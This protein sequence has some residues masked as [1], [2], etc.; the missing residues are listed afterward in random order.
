MI[1]TALAFIFGFLFLYDL[2]RSD[3]P[4]LD[5]DA[6]DCGYLI[7]L[8]ALTL[9]FAWTPLKFWRLEKTL[10]KHAA[11][12][13]E[14]SE[15]T[16]SCTSVFDS[17]FDPYDMTRA[18]SAYF[19]TGEIIFHYGWCK[20]FMGYLEDP[21]Y[22]SDDELFSMHL[23]THEVMHIRGERNE[24]ETDCQA[25]QRNHLLGEQV[26]IDPFVARQNA[27]QYYETLYKTHPYYDPS[28]APHKALDEKLPNSIWNN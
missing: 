16:V 28:C 10:T 24:R 17:I 7:V 1:L 22:I 2:F 13:S 26:G 3:K 25:I 15:A 6:F 12:F 21:V 8:A 9:T 23:F 19:D 20:R 14:R 5:Y 18:A 4:L 11:V 27:I